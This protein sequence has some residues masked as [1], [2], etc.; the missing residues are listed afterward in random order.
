MKRRNNGRILTCGKY[1]IQ[2]LEE[3]DGANPL[4]MLMLDSFDNMASNQEELEQLHH[5]DTCLKNIKE[6]LGESQL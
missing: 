6:N 4:E 1:L 3:N 2:L 5:S